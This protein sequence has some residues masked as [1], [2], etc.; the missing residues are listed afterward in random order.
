M[1]RGKSKKHRRLSDGRHH[2][3]ERAPTRNDIRGPLPA[4]PLP[5]PVAAKSG[6]GKRSRLGFKDRG[7]PGERVEFLKRASSAVELRI[8]G[9]SFT[10]IAEELGYASRGAA[11]DAYKAGYA[12]LTDEIRSEAQDAIKHQ[13]IRNRSYRKRVLTQAAESGDQIAGSMAAL[14]VDKFDAQLRGL[15]P[16]AA[17]DL[18]AVPAIAGPDGATGLCAK[19][20]SPPALTDPKYEYTRLEVITKI[21]LES[22]AHLVPLKTTD[23]EGWADGANAPALP[24]QTVT[25]ASPQVAGARFEKIRD[26]ELRDLADYNFNDH[27]IL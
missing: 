6:S 25:P 18:D 3:P 13:L 9:A 15:Q 24:P 4:E 17:R 26:R 19:C 8:M 7:T 14:A 22:N 27:E 1:P 5:E 12:A 2:R 21:L 23:D 10:E 20:G 16:G 11:F